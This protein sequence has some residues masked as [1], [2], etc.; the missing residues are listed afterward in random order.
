[1]RSR[2]PDRAAGRYWVTYKADGTRYMLLLMNYGA[3]VIGRD[4]E[5]QRVEVRFPA[6]F[7]NDTSTANPGVPHHMTLLDGEMVIDHDP[8]TN[9]YIRKCLVYDLVI[10]QG[11]SWMELPWKQ[12]F[13]KLQEIISVRNY[14]KTKIDKHEWPFEYRYAEEPFDVQAKMFWC[15][16]QVEGI[17]KTIPKLLHECDGF[18]FQAYEDQY[19]IGT[20]EELLKWKY[21]HMNSVDFRFRQSPGH[22]RIVFTE[23]DIL[24]V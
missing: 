20:H 18:I 8:E 23:S 16:G 19:Q 7:R 17:V 3:Y 14:E 10:H 5:V 12:R 13:A 9:Q 15:M 21:P 11:Q 22:A 1:M 2:D 24:L 4:F 6:C